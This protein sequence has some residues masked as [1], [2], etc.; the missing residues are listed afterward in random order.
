MP[1]K[2]I[3]VEVIYKDPNITDED[4]AAALIFPEHTD[5]LCSITRFEYDG[6]ETEAYLY[7]AG[8]TILPIEHKELVKMN[9]KDLEEYLDQLDQEATDVYLPWLEVTYSNE[10]NRDE[11][12]FVDDVYFGS[13][14]EAIENFK[15]NAESWVD[16]FKNR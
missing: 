12:I 10:G 7:K 2:K 14:K 8:E 6:G 9:N 15:E 3:N 16:Y 13:H 5:K 11:E 4:D 1:A